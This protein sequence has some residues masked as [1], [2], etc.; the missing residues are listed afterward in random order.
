MELYNNKLNDKLKFKVNSEGI[1]TSNM[2][3][4]LILTTENNKNYFFTGTLYNGVCTFDIPELTAYETEDKGKIKF[5]IVSEDLYFP[6]WEDT[7]EVK[8]KQTIVLEQL[9]KEVQE[10]EKP[11]ISAS[12]MIE[13]RKEEKPLKSEKNKEEPV[14]KDIKEVNKEEPVKEKKKEILSF[15][16]FTKK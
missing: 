14:K 12:P 3:A 4:R 10:K 1:N 16:I 11:K 15:D 7:F 13:K 2:E 9:V 8:T 5:E 6:V